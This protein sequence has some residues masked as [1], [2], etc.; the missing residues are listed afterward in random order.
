MQD[1]VRI[2]SVEVLS[3]DWAVLKKTVLDYRRRDGSWETQIRQTYDR[4]DGAVILPYDPER[5][6]V[7][8]VKQFRFPA[9]VTGH[10]EPLIEACAGLIDED[11]PETAI[12]R[13][14]EEELG[15]RLRHVKHLYTS[16]MSPGSLTERLSFFT[17]DYSPGD[18]ISD[19]GGHPDEGE[20]IE[21]L[22]ITLDETLAAIRDGRIVDAKTIMLIQHLKL[23]EAAHG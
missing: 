15:Y 21:V 2:K 16:Y 9:Y 6:T 18:R 5:G 20:D 17:A 14:A 8:L 22:E 11:D 23:E 19:G 3:D 7:L 10:E 1:R 4:G 12:R 13:E